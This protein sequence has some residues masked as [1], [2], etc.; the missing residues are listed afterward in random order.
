M[1]EAQAKEKYR[2]LLIRIAKHYVSLKDESM[3]MKD[4]ADEARGAG[5]LKGG[6]IS[7][8]Y[9]QA[10]SLRKE[11]YKIKGI[12]LLEKDSMEEFFGTTNLYTIAKQPLT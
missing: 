10:K 4:M 12:L 9:C 6:V 7:G 8:M 2:S 11:A 3:A 5:V 1:T